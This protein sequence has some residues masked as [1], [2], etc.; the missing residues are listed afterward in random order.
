MSH[1][2]TP[3]PFLPPPAGTGL[4]SSAWE[5]DI[6]GGASREK[7]KAEEKRDL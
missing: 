4:T 3:H 2:P 6:G 7:L 5:S 1:E